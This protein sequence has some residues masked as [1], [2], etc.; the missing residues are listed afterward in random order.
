ME[1]SLSGS[2]ENEKFWKELQ[3]EWDLREGTIY[4]NHGSFGPPPRKVQK[5]RDDWSHLLDSQPMDFFWRKF[6]PA[7]LEARSQLA[8]FVGTTE[9]NLVC[10]DNA[11]YGMNVVAQSIQ[12]SA[13]D[14]VLLTNHEYGAVHRV[15]ER[16]CRRAGAP[17]PKIAT[18]PFPVDSQE[19]V[20][21]SIFSQ[22]TDRTR[23]LV[24]S[25]ITSPTAMTLPVASLCQRARKISLTTCIDGPHAVAQLP[26]DI[27]S[28]DCDFYTAS[29]HKWLCAP[30]G[31]GFLYVHPRQ[32]AAIEPV[33]LSWGRLGDRPRKS[34]V[35]D[36]NWIGSRDPAPFLAIPAAIQFLQEVGCDAF[37]AR[38]HY[39]ATYARERLVELSG[40]QPPL[41]ADPAWYGSMTHVPLKTEDPLAL[42]TALWEQHAIEVPIF[43]FQG[44]DFIRVSCHLYNDRSQIDR[45]VVALD[46]LLM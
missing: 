40:Q 31:S 36:F 39:L 43:G 8:K 24:V 33:V 21:E 29:C 32:H 38:T 23:L 7:L 41:P 10:V 18:L 19:Q 34:W 16:A 37:R 2:V 1:S 42:Q 35:D 45:L 3:T 25:H 5:V 6:E 13:E 14:E 26:L 12:L 4:L 11:T 15:W 20:I 27:D 22:V 28:L 30:F 46:K 17:P 44:R 9:P